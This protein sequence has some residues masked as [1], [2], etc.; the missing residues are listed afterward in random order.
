[1]EPKL[2]S[3]IAQLR[4]PYLRETNV[5]MWRSAYMSNNSLA[6]FL[7]AEDGEPLSTVSVNLEDY[8]MVPQAGH[9]FIK[10]QDENE[11]MID[12][13]REAGVIAPTERTVTYGY[14]VVARECEVTAT[15]S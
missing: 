2:I 9:I 15:K 12:A 14:G 8:G 3:V 6:I 7:T 1:M 4:T 10:D 11:G 5:H 13:L